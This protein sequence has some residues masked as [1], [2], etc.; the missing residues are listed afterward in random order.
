[1][2]CE[3]LLTIKDFC[4]CLKAGK[5]TVWAGV[6]TGRLPKPIKVMGMTRWRRSEIETFLADLGTNRT[7]K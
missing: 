4:A 7:T 6:K 1:M 5:T 3:E 2:Q